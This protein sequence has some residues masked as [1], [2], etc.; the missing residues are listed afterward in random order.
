VGGG[1]CPPPYW[2]AL[3]CALAHVEAGEGPAV[4]ADLRHARQAWPAD[5]TADETADLT[6][7]RAVAEQLGA[8]QCSDR[9]ADPAPF[10][11]AE[12]AELPA[13]RSCRRWPI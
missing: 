3:A 4:Q 1:S 10:V 13:D 8:D 12:A 5:E 7:L 6:V 9:A 11:I 2:L